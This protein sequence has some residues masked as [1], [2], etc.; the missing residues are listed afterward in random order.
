[1]MNKVDIKQLRRSISDFAKP[2]TLKGV[3]IFSLDLTVYALAIIGVIFLDNFGL[4]LLCGILAGLKMASL[5]AI[6]HDAAHDSFT[7]NRRLNKIIGRISFLPVLHNYSLWLIAHN[8]THHHIPNVKD[9]N[10]WSPLSKQEYEAMSSWRKLLEKFY[11]SPAGIWLNYLVERWWKYK[12]YP[13]KAIVGQRKLIHWLDFSL[14]M[15]I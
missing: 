12:C 9:V 1:M 3:I 7:G 13:F 10:S 2:S 4:K 11:R 15:D 6:A 14:I 8:R 5:F